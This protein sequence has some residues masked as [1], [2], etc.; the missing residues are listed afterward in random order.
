MALW[1]KPSL[2]G[3]LPQ[4]S[5]AARAQVLQRISPADKFATTVYDFR[6][7]AMPQCGEWSQW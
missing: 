5:R 3:R 6:R 7:L 1:R 2:A 4:R